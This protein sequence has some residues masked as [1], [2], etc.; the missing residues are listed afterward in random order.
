MSPPPNVGD[1]D[2]ATFKQRLLEGIDQALTGF[3]SR[4]IPDHARKVML[5]EKQLFSTDEDALSKLY[6]LVKQQR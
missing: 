6:E 5:A 3:S 4:F 2:L 1:L